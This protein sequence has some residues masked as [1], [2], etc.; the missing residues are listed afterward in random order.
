M[1]QIIRLI[2][3]D[4]FTG[5][6]YRTE[7]HNDDNKKDDYHNEIKPLLKKELTD[8]IKGIYGTNGDFIIEDGKI[9]YVS[10]K[11]NPQT[12]K[13]IKRSVP[14]GIPAE[15]YFE[16]LSFNILWITY[17]FANKHKI[18]I[19]IILE[20]TEEKGTLQIRIE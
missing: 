17:N 9:V 5:N 2:L 18:N 12:G 20:H 15:D 3:I 7:N 11:T 8:K 16:R 10:T 13:R 19:T 14:L 1:A 4:N 6:V